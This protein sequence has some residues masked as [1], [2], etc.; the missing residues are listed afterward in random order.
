MRNLIKADMARIL[1][2]K[3]IYVGLVFIIYRLIDQ[4][5]EQIANDGF[6]AKSFI[7]GIHAAL[8]DQIYGALYLVI[9]VFFAVFSNEIPSKA[10]QCILGRGLT[11]DKLILA[12]LI[13]SAILL[14]GYF[15]IISAIIFMLNDESVAM[16]AIQNRNLVIYIIFTFLR[17]YGYIVFSA[18]IMFLTNSTAAG[19]VSCVAFTVI[20][21]LTFK[22]LEMFTE[23]TMYDYTFDG[24]LDL[25]YGLIE[26]GRFGW[27]IIPAALYLVA[28]VV[29]TVIFFRRREFEF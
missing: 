18:M 5:F 13:D 26:A 19:I 23:F 27:Q 24:Q 16:S 29:I 11:R 2:T 8:T 28:G 10:M 20:F 15:V 12:K 21:K 14:A 3:L 17:F 7:D 25:S 22:V 9:P 6:G 4:I 1:R